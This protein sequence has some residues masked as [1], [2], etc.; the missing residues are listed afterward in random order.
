MYRVVNLTLNQCEA[1]RKRWLV[2]DF[3]S[4]MRHG[5][6]WGIGT[7]IEDYKLSD[8][9]KVSVEMTFPHSLHHGQRS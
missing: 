5:T 2:G 4:G 3:D 1:Q 7:N 9:L 6:Y 8:A